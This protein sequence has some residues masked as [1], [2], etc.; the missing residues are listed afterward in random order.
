MGLFKS[1]FSYIFKE[2]NS[3][4]ETS[5][6]IEIVKNNTEK[7]TD[8]KKDDFF[9][10]LENKINNYPY[11][12]DNLIEKNIYLTEAIF[13]EMLNIVNEI[14][15][16]TDDAVYNAN[17]ESLI[18]SFIVT[19]NATLKAIKVRNFLLDNHV[20]EIGVDEIVSAFYILNVAIFEMRD[21]LQFKN[22]EIKNILLTIY[23]GSTGDLNGNI[24]NVTLEN[25]N[26]I[27]FITKW[28][29]SHKFN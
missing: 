5:S 10:Y 21:T 12:F 7:H 11:T 25:V 27:K 6:V 15:H 4:K 16:L 9:E 23:I 28:L 29:D 1:L 8:I 18:N 26:K 20:L 17:K 2:K 14:K 13:L 22:E 19:K 3:E 24:S